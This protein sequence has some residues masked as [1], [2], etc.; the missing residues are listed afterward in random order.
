MST[1]SISNSNYTNILSL[2]LRQ[3]KE[4]KSSLK[5]GGTV[6]T[7]ICHN[8]VGRNVLKATYKLLK[9]SSKFSKVIKHAW[10]L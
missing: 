10:L 6:I 3:D 7:S 5:K 8:Y 1:I 2:A 9:L 4:I